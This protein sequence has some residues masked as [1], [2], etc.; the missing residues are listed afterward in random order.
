M[1]E[2]TTA[3]NE[4]NYVTDV[5]DAAV[6]TDLEQNEE[7]VIEGE[8][9]SGTWVNPTVA[10]D[11]PRR[12]TR[13]RQVSYVI[14]E[15]KPSFMRVVFGSVVMVSEEIRDRAS[16]SGDEDQI[17]QMMQAAV[18]QAVS[19]EQSLDQRPFSNLR[20]GTIG[21]VSGLLDGAGGGAGRVS[22]MTDSAVQMA[23][24]VIDPVWNSF[25]FA[26][27]HKPALRV[28]QAGEEKVNQWIRRGRV[29][30]IRSRA[31]AEVSIN[32]FVEESVTEIT[33]N[34][35]V[36]MIV[37]E[38]IASQSTS[39]I[40]EI[41][42]EARERLVS[43]DL[44]LMGK[45][46]RDLVAEPEFRD[47]FLQ[48]TVQRHPRFQ[49][50]QL[51]NSLAGTYAGPV[52]R[53]IAFLLDVV[54]LIIAVGLVSSFTVNAI[55]LF[56]LSDLVS[57]Y[58]QSGGLISTVF[59]VF[60]AM[61]NFLVVS[62]YFIFSWNWTGAT[63]GDLIFGLRVVNKQGGRVSFFRSIMRLI[64]AYISAASLMIGF[65]WALFDSRRQGWHDKLGGTVVLYNWPAKP[66][67]TFL[68]E[69]VMANV[70]TEE[71]AQNS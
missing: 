42:D 59:V 61:F 50:A 35:Q 17:Q 13:A 64:G 45:L 10:A 6:E 8:I 47:S 4:A 56:G 26:P 1:S 36:K 11:D 27:L 65:I 62:F 68:Y 53:L 12:T 41:L 31:L 29:E 44:I 9:V 46:R 2:E 21:L 7:E 48:E 32:N 38:V 49:R 54:I 18:N 15:A 60:V 22:Q 34:E 70:D 30:E 69:R 3:E 19:Q 16:D 33:E 24:R 52:T 58:R 37:Q 40:A 57:T 28:E 51:R 55:E 63:P 23:G 67:E 66:D 20:Y 39:L 71:P 14:P 43:L 25:L 5:T